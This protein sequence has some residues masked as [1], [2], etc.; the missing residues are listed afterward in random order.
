MEQFQKPIWGN[1]PYTEKAKD[2]PIPLTKENIGMFLYPA[3]G[4]LGFSDYD[5]V[6]YSS[7]KLTVASMEIPAG[8]FFD[9]PDYHPGDEVYFVL[10]GIITQYNPR[11]GQCVRVKENEVLIVPEGVWHTAYN[12]EQQPLC[13][14]TIIAPKIV[15]DQNFPSDTHIAKKLFLGD[16]NDEHISVNGQKSI[17]F[18]SLDDLGKW[19][20]EGATLRAEQLLYPISEEDK[21]LCIQG[22]GDPV[23]VKISVSNDYLTV[24]EYILPSGGV[25]CRHTEPICFSGETVLIG[26]DCPVV[27]YVPRL[28]LTYRIQ[29]FEGMYMPAGMPF[30]LLNYHHEPVRCLFAT[31]SI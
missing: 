27:L 28:E 23:L 7:E 5:H 11:S 30:Q 14:I 13:A 19:P 3:T 10:D 4:D 31:T 1:H 8:S 20:K 17:R 6:F 15:D 22:D 29:R 21:L 25:R 26:I 24:G 2:H 9:P 12:F 18:G 16:T